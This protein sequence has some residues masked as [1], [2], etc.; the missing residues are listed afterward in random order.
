MTR[1]CFFCDKKLDDSN[2]K[3]RQGERKYGLKATFYLCPVCDDKLGYFLK[4]HDSGEK[5]NEV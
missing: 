1:R 5:T 2:L 4:F 3:L